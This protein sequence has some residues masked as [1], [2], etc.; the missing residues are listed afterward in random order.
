M[1]TKRHGFR[2]AGSL[3]VAPA[4]GPA[5]VLVGGPALRGWSSS[6][7]RRAWW[8][9]S[10]ACA[11]KMRPIGGV[12]VGQKSA[13]VVVALS[14]SRIFSSCVAVGDAV[15]DSLA[16][17][18]RPTHPVRSDPCSVG[19]LLF[20]HRRFHVPAP[21]PTMST[22]FDKYSIPPALDR[23]FQFPFD[24]FQFGCIVFQSM[25]ELPRPSSG[26]QCASI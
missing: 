14:K 19:R 20:L 4:G 5:G 10:N 9:R 21:Q 1:R 8:A 6:R 26:M 13:F 12:G 23:P 2:A 16:W 11:A 17:P 22:A 25:A 18:L 24:Y 7:V 3:L 15:F